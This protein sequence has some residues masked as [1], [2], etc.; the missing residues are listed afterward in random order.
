MQ[1]RRVR[2]LAG[3]TGKQIQKKKKKKEKNTSS[4]PLTGPGQ[5]NTDEN[6]KTNSGINQVILCCDL[7]QKT[8]LV[9]KL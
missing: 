6:M 7:P 8:L 5:S 1:E 2:E 9:A 4:I 3:S